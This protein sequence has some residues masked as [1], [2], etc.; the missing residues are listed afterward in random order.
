MDRKKYEIENGILTKYFGTEEDVVIDEDIIEIGEGAFED[1]MIVS[2]TINS[3]VLKKIEKKA[4]MN[5]TFLTTINIK[6]I[7]KSIGEEAFKNCFSLEKIVL[8][9]GLME[10][11]E[12][13]FD[14]C[15]DLV[16]IKIP[17]SV[18]LIG[19]NIFN[20]IFSNTGPVIVG[21]SQI[22]RNYCADKHII[23]TTS[24]DELE[25]FFVLR[26]K[27]KKMEFNI[28]DEKIEVL[29]STRI[30]NEIIESFKGR[31]E[32]FF[33]ILQMYIP[34]KSIFTFREQN[35]SSMNNQIDGEVN[36]VIKTL[37]K[38]HVFISKQHVTFRMSLVLAEMTECFKEMN[39]LIVKLGKIGK[40]AM[41]NKM[42]SLKYQVNSQVTGVG[43]GILTGDPLVFAGYAL[44]DFLAKNKQ[45]NTA[46]ANA[47]IEL[48]NYSNDIKGAIDAAFSK[49]RDEQVYPELKRLSKKLIDTMCETALEALSDLNIIDLEF[50]E[51]FN[52]DKARQI[53]TNATT[54]K[55]SAVAMAIQ[56]DPYCEETYLFAAKKDLINDELMELMGFIGISSQP[57]LDEVIKSSSISALGIERFKSSSLNENQAQL[58]LNRALDAK[59][60]SI[61]QLINSLKL[62]TNNNDEESITE[63][64]QEFEKKVD[65]GIWNKI[66]ENSFD[67]EK[68]IINLF[69]INPTREKE[70][71]YQIGYCCV[72]QNQYNQLV[73]EITNK[74]LENDSLQDCF[75]IL[76][77]SKEMIN[78]EDRQSIFEKKIKRIKNDLMH[79]SKMDKRVIDKIEVAKI[80]EQIIL[81]NA[82]NVSVES[83]TEVL[84]EHFL[85]RICLD[86]AE[87]FC[88]FNTRNANEDFW[89]ENQDTKKNLEDE[90]QWI[91]EQIRQLN[92]S[93]Y[94]YKYDKEELLKTRKRNIQNVLG[95]ICA[96]G[97]YKFEEEERH[98]I[99]G[100][101]K[102]LKEIEDVDKK[103]KKKKSRTK[104]ILIVSA[105]AVGILIIILCA[106]GFIIQ[107][108]KE[109][110]KAVEIYGQEIVDEIK[111]LE[112]GDVYTFGEFAAEPGSKKQPLEWIVLDKSIN[113]LEVIMITKYV[114]D[115][116][117]IISKSKFENST[118]PFAE[119]K[120]YS[121]INRK[122][123]IDF[124]DQETQ[125]IAS[126]FLK[127]GENVGR[128]TYLSEDEANKYFKSDEKRKADYLNGVDKN[129]DGWKLRDCYTEEKDNFYDSTVLVLNKDVN[130]DGKILNAFWAGIRPA[131]RLDLTT[132]N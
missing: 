40:D 103:E 81:S 44:D 72:R 31:D 23:H 34:S 75:S 5:C 19:D 85:N 33:S 117:I 67:F 102:L 93:K 74:V 87:E 51:K 9:E 16:Y 98:I 122:G 22:V 113:D 111:N 59:K 120:D 83:Q 118:V 54:N 35:I 99:D 68:K 48:N 18:I 125:L 60:E 38:Y 104:A 126:N 96:P 24:E 100:K 10:I 30:H 21:K 27:I 56:Y 116:Y 124:N 1:S 109:Y 12:K 76:K 92:E 73:T 57:V 115:S 64:Q 131:I 108:K 53:I 28:F 79:N 89:K 61:I 132:K 46:V 90:L 36:F 95:R 41:D 49:I 70:L 127:N 86:I 58:L 63:I 7:K 107:P 25:K 112:I 78:C 52:T 2:V 32:S 11:K 123:Y 43:Y 6:T 114:I 105:A 4:F 26:K 13:A 84:G 8:P 101:N 128:I 20:G 39:E 55:E 71:Y 97:Y 129:C 69:S 65:I 88:T 15:T 106:Y 91:E 47:K 130:E 77:Q 45:R 121:Y 14:S 82:G 119:T 17:D 29:N 110:N 50:D 94:Y 66:K 37:S 62:N 80:V 42:E 3:S